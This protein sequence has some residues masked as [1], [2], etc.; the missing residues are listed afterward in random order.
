MAFVIIDSQM[1]LNTKS[2]IAMSLR[3][4]YLKGHLMAFIIIDCQ[5]VL[6]N[7]SPIAMSLA[8]E[9]WGHLMHSDCIGCVFKPQIYKSNNEHA[10]WLDFSIVI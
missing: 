6:D 3:K 4:I 9:K 5:M 2:P 1:V 7:R 8:N 10:K